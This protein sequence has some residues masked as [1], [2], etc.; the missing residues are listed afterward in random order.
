MKKTDDLSSVFPGAGFP[1]PST[2]DHIGVGP[3][4]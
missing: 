4:V 3:A 1:A 2:T